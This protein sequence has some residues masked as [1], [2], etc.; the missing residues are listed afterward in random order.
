MKVYIVQLD[1][2]LKIFKVRSEDE[3]R[4]LEEYQKL[5]IAKG[6]SIQEAIQQFAALKKDSE[7]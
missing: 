4:F 1:D 7:Y 5:I 3:A 2:E 6:N